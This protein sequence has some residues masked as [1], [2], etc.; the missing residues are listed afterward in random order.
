MKLTSVI[1]AALAATS[2]LAAVSATPV[3][4]QGKTPL[5]AER[6][7]LM[8]SNFRSLM[9]IKNATDPAAA[10]GPAKTIMQNT[11]M[12]ESKWPQGSGGGASRAKA[13]IWQNLGDVE[14]RLAN[15]QGAA[16]DVLKIAEGGGDIG[17]VKAAFGKLAGN[18]GGCH[19]LYRGPK[20]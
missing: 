9:K 7:K 18:C 3:S 5:Q 2:I 12:L 10:I 17:A 8:I 1:L 6:T 11:K 19:K 16:A 20:K 4:A 14:A 15:L 13:A